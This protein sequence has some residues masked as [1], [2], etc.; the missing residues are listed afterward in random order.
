MTKPELLKIMSYV[1]A[2][3]GI[4]LSEERVLVWWD[5]FRGVDFKLA[6]KAARVLAGR[7]SFG[8][9]KAQDFAE[10]LAEVEELA[11]GAETWGEGWDKFTR[12][13]LRF[14]I[15]RIEEILPALENVSPLAARAMKTGVRE[16]LTSD[17]SDVPTIR[18]QFR[19]RYEALQSRERTVRRMPV[20]L[21]PS[22]PGES[23]ASDLV[24]GVV[25]ALLEG[26]KNA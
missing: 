23:K 4:A 21:R 8:A 13:A 19:Q 26:N 25:K 1:F 14:G 16:F 2:E 22:L 10:A 11:T 3:H 7:K 20:D 5:Q 24:G 6:Q 17:E 9:P 18:A 12:I 15:Y